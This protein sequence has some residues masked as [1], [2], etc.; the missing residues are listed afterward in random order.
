MSLTLTPPNGMLTLHRPLGD[1]TYP[2]ASAVL[3]VV[4]GEAGELV[5]L[6]FEITTSQATKSLPDTAQYNPQPKA[7]VRVRLPQVDLE[8]LATTR[9]SVPL[10][11]EEDDD[12]YH[13]TLYYFEH[14]NLDN[15]QIEVRGREGDVFHIRWSAE[16]EDLNGED[17][18]AAM[19]VEIEGDFTF[20]HS[21][22]A[23]KEYARQFC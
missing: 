14:Q 10:G 1:E 8:A 21:D 5:D 9:F 22:E 11:R 20:L 19:G 4:D 23:I 18:G 12:G 6:W 16:A 13:A 15:N 2:L 7:E 3:F 17:P